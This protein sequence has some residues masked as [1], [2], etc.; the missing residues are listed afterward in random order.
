MELYVKELG[1]CESVPMEPL[2]KNLYSLAEDCYETLKKIN[3][4]KDDVNDVGGA[5]S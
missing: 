3:F 1:K 4:L 2:G 5:V